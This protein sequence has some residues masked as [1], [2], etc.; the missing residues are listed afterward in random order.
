[1]KNEA[2]DGLERGILLPV[3][4]DDVSVPV[5]FKTT[6]AADLRGWQGQPDAQLDDVLMAAVVETLGAAAPHEPSM[7]PV[8][9]RRAWPAWPIVAVLALAA[10]AVASWLL[11]REVPI[12]ESERPYLLVVPFDVFAADARTWEPFSDQVT[13]EIIRKLRNV[14]GLR[15]VPH[16]SAFAFKGNKMREHIRATLPEVQF[17][18]DGQ[19]SVTG[20]N[21]LRIVAE[22]EELNVDGR[23]VWDGDFVSRVDNT[24]IFGVQSDIA[25]EVSRS[26][27]VA[28]LD[29]ESRDIEKLPTRNLDAYRIYGEARDKQRQGTGDALRA[30]IALFDQAIEIDPEF[31][32]AYAQKAD[33]YRLLMTFFEAPVEMLPHVISAA[34]RALALDPESADARA[35]LGLA[36]LHAWSWHDAFRYL[37]EAQERDPE[38]GQ[39]YL[40][41]ALY[42]SGIGEMQLAAKALTLADELDPLNVEIANFGLLA[43]LNMREFDLAVR[44]ADRKTDL[45]SDVGWFLASASNPYSQVGNHARAIRI[46]ER[47]VSLD[48]GNA[49]AVLFLAQAYA[50]AGRQED[51]RRALS[52]A[53]AIDSYVCPYETSLVHVALNEP[54][55]AFELLLEQAV[56]AR[57]NC[58]MLTRQDPRLDPLRGDPRFEELLEDVGLDDESVGHYSR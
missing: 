52:D 53:E 54:D 6:Q 46:A 26:L 12:T 45:H 20:S 43:L 3:L 49:L 10:V 7:P 28:I 19:V 50:R 44:W 38:I 30:S 4:L 37:S 39:V 24:N 47:G 25:R 27:Q 51:A 32:L 41:L 22:L 14:S 17:V 56:P 16:P 23:M 11:T 8:R 42:Y 31:A 33:S 2:M 13:R 55:R 9:A 18:L 58:L 40:G 21:E 35:S 57:S 36:Y 34:S 5:A 29:R 1:V 48:R 15:V